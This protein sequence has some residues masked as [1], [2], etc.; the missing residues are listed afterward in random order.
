MKHDICKTYKNIKL[1]AIET[2]DLE[3]LRVWRND[4]TT[5]LKY[6]SKID[7]ITPEAQ[8]GWYNRDLENQ[9]SYTF[10]IEETEELKRLIGSTA[11]YNFNNDTAEFGRILIGDDAA[12]G[13]GWGVLA[14]S[15]C[16]HI[17]FSVFDLTGIVAYVHEDNLAAWKAYEKCGF[18]VT[19]KRDDELE[20]FIA[21]E[22][23][24]KTNSFME[25]I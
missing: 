7:Y 16:L 4:G 2:K 11:L 22:M 3:N 8:L 14:T 17:G 6:L 1:R 20:I 23:F 9:N 21:K 19:G 13:R 15:V 18:E 25:G 24:Y 5:T 12:R 10:A